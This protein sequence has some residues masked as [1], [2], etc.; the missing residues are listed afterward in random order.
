M[1]NHF[2]TAALSLFF[3]RR[4]AKPGSAGSSR[5]RW[6]AV[7]SLAAAALV[8]SCCTPPT[9]PIVEARYPGRIRVACVGDSITF[10]Y[11][12]PERDRNSYP[13][14]LQDLLGARWEVRNFGVNGATALK[15]GTRP[16]S[17]GP[18]FQ[19]A[20]AFK[21]DV[22]IV[23]LGTNDTNARSWPAHRQDFAA[24]YRELVRRFQ[25]LASR[26]R[27]YACAPVPLFRDRGKEYDTDQILVAEVIPQVKQVA[28]EE[29][30]GLIDLYAAFENR[31]ERFPDGVHPD[32]R[33]ARLMAERICRQ[34]TGRMTTLQQQDGGNGS[35]SLQPPQQVQS[36]K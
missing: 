22:V 1:P 28:R 16:Y 20:L 32:A 3:S 2:V 11:G 21:P 19:E 30:L 31:P 6:A 35:P 12:I 4:Q 14:Q 24:D 26:P 7:V 8:S 15:Q 5:P 23:E 25:A 18:A 29:A 10:G 17:L 34:L 36:A 13:A 27:V 9:G 33:G